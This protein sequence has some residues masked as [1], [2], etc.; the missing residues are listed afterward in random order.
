MSTTFQKRLVQTLRNAEVISDED[1]E[2][3]VETA[4]KDD[5]SLFEALIESK[6]FEE[7]ELLGIIGSEAGVPP[8]DLE[9]VTVAPEI[10][11]LMDQ[12][13]AERHRVLPIAKIGQVLTLAVA[14]PFD[15]VQVDHLQL[16]LKCDLRPVVA[17]DRALKEAISELFGEGARELEALVG[18]ATSDDDMIVQSGE[19]EESDDVDLS[20]ISGETSPVIKLTN[21][22]I[23]NAIREKASDIHIEPFETK[24][25][26]RY[27][28]D[29]VLREVLSPPRNLAGS[30]ASR[31]KIMASLDIAEK[32]KPQDGK[33]Q[34]KIEGRAVDFRVSTL[35]VVHGEK[36]VMRVLDTGNLAADL[37]NLGFEPKNLEDFQSAIRAPYGMILITG[38]TGSG[39]STTLYSSVR[40]LYSDETNFVTVEDPVE[41]QLAGINQVPVNPK[42]GVTFAAALRS[43]LRQDPDVILIGEIRDAETIEIAVKAALTGH[44]VLSTLHTNDAAS[45]ISRMIDM[46]L[47]PFLVAT[48]VV[49]V[50]AQRL[51]RK[52]CVNCRERVEIPKER[53]LAVGMLESETVETELYRA[54]GCNRCHQGYRGRFAI[55]E[56]LNVTDTI[57]HAILAGKSAIEIKKVA[58]DEGMLTLRRSALLNAQ[59]GNTSLEEVLR[60]TMGDG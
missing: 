10:V 58:M 17:S 9:R 43:I 11:D 33:F 30:I 48:S 14:D 1:L 28:Q 32:R 29:G 59:R 53:M 15:V 41:Y 4:S 37:G 60:V 23:A 42:R 20:D 25:R 26:V 31:V 44:L 47:D 40:E 3:A 8:I 5:G 57:K 6:A 51:C 13:T 27:R 35:P 16:L 39:K 21:M 45:A 7:K 12:A 19:K 50:A 56:T 24:L 18:D 2:A 36:I 49:M 52:L 55:I 38:P 34:V 46:G 54:V 22:I